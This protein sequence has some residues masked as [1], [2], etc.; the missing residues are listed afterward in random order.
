MK[1][2]FFMKDTLKKILGLILIVPGAFIL[3]IALFGIIG[4]GEPDDFKTGVGVIIFALS[5][6]V[7]GIL[8]Y[9]QG[10]ALSRRE[11][12][13]KKLASMLRTYRRMSIQDMASI[14]AVTELEVHNL[15]AVAIDLKLISGHID[16]TTNEFFVLT[17][18]DNIKKLTHCPYC[19]APVTGIFHEGET[20][21]CSSCGQLFH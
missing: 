19:G 13:I 7:P 10:Q 9:R 12:K 2:F 3:L 15:L 18:I 1:F 14:L 21:K 8:I 17:S 6:I 16:R 11:K 20:A 5:L 4:G